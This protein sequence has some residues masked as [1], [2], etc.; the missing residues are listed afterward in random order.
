MNFSY[1]RTYTGQIT[2]VIFDWAGTTVDFG[3]MAPAQVFAEIFSQKGVQITSSEAREPMG[4]QKRDH[5]AAIAAMPPVAKQWKEVHNREINEADID[6]MFHNFVPLQQRV[7]RNHANVIDGVKEVVE[8]LKEAGIK[9]GSTTGYTGAIM[10]VVTPIA[11]EQGYEPD[12]LVT[13]DWKPAGR[14]A[15]WMLFENLRQLGIYPLESVVKVGD[16]LPDVEEGLNAGVWS[17]A[18]VDSSNEVGMTFE[19]W[20]ELTEQEKEAIRKPVRVKFQRAGAHYVIDSLDELVDVI[21]DIEWELSNG[22][23]P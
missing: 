12:Y 4:L 6:E 3:C 18:V 23:K 11:K 16:T 7:V 8:E 13:G 17:V 10:D 2:A 19:A 21:D 22:N 20:S 14:P 9:I 15:P 5:I 1:K